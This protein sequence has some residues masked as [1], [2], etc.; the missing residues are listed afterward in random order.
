VSTVMHAQA[1]KS[2]LHL[3]ELRGRA[4]FM[5]LAAE[6]D[7]LADAVAPGQA[8]HRHA[9]LRIWLDNFAPL[10][11]VRVLVLRGPDGRV[12]A[13]LPLVWERTRLYGAPVR[14]LAAAANAHSC[15]FDLLARA[16]REAASALWAHLA[17]QR[18]WD[19][20]R[21]TDVP[22]GGAGWRLLEE[23]RRAGA[24]AGTWESLQSPWFPLPESHE[25][26]LGTLQARF[27]ANVR[28]RRK[29]LEEKGRVTFE[30][31]EG[32]AELMERLE[33]GFLLEASGWKGRRGTA[34][35]QDPATRGFYMELAR[36][37]AYEGTLALYFLRLDRRP[38]AFHF[39][40]Q[41]DG[42]YL[43][44]KPGYDEGLKECSPGQLLMEE[45][46]RDLVGR[47]VREF[48]FL[49]P[50]MVWK[51]D[52]TDRVRAH[53]WLYVF[54]DGAFGRALC[55]AKFRWAPAAKEAMAR[56]TR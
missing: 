28:R 6:W 41:R 10:A 7:A 52:W 12:E 48:D 44:L 29:K 25:A 26:F 4:A 21:L 16:P 36:N 38:V 56:W 17:A 54:R 27:R 45:V 47:G 5:E 1:L 50:D 39:G 30:R 53:A 43:L 20:L 34:M 37:A 46:V 23:A 3:E 14:Q 2:P 9:F 51:R 31:V 13:G 55:A 33:E 49:G 32:G 8:F 40:L 24:P 11:D 18:D 19:V 42:R 35:A 15:R 22:E